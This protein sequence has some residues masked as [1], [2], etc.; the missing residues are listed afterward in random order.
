MSRIRLDAL[1]ATYPDLIDLYPL[2]PTQRGMLFHTLYAPEAGVYVGHLSLTL[3]TD[4]SIPVFK[5]AW[6]QLLERHPVLRTIF[7]WEDLDEPVQVVCQGVALP[8]EQYDWRDLD[9][10]TQQER[11]EECLAAQRRRGF[12][13]AC[14]P[15]MRL[16]LIRLSDDVSRLIWSH[17]HLLIDGW[18][19]NVIYKEL[20]TLYEA[21]LVGQSVHL[22]RTSSFRD[23]I[24]WLTKQ[25]LAQAERFWRQT[26]A[27]FYRSTPLGVDSAA[28]DPRVRVIST[29]K[30]AF[31]P[32]PQ[33]AWSP[34]P[35]GTS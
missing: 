26:L 3:H 20:S 9:P 11:L 8:L 5:R 7:V 34:S 10:L 15:L 12:D 19:M 35:S 30:Q 27:G 25:D 6:Q 28:G 13:L 17:H 23:H 31:Q 14:P 32:R 33:T 4:L 22:G 16:L 21:A 1:Q 29:S 24:D 18:S 2:S